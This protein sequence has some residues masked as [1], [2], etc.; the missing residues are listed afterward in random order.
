MAFPTRTAFLL[1]AFGAVSLV[2]VQ[3]QSAPPDTVVAEAPPAAE[4]PVARD[5]N[6]ARVLYNEGVAL[7]RENNHAEAL[8]RFERGIRF[9]DRN[10]R[11]VYGRAQAL[12]GLDRTAEAITAFEQSI[13]LARAA[14]DTETAQAAQR[15]VGQLAYREA[16][17]KLQAN[18]LPAILAQEALPLLQTARDNG[19][20][21]EALPYQFA[22]VYNALE[23]H[24]EAVPYAEAA[25]EAHR[26][27]SDLSP[28][29]IEL[30]IA[31]RGAG[32]LAGARQAFEAARTGAWSAWAE[33]YLRE[34]DAADGDDS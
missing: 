30:G 27:A 8:A 20:Q 32:D 15:A 12:M 1:A 9:D 14:R 25:V 2:P 4:A 7:L 33:H 17:A 31:K 13:V 6:Q 19:V 29:Y 24:A 5:E 23:R 28:Y 21:T 11:N 16:S 3:A 22:R 34:L 10:A 26:A 18:P